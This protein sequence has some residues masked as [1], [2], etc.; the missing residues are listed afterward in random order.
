MLTVSPQ[1]RRR[2]IMGLQGLY[3]GRRWQ[4]K[5]GV[6]DAFAAMGELQIDPLNV[7]ARSHDI[8]LWGR[9]TGYKP[10]C[11]NDLLYEDRKF[12]DYG[13]TV[14]IRPMETLP[15]WRLI[16]ERRK[17]SPRY[18]Q[19]ITAY[20]TILDTVREHI[21][22]NGA[23]TSRM[24][25]KH[26]DKLTNSGYRT[27]NVTGQALYHLWLTGE[28]MTS[29]REGFERVYD[30]RESVAPSEYHHVAEV[31]EAED[32][33]ARRVLQV[34]GMTTTKKWRN[35]FSG[36]IERKVTPEE[37]TQR[38][39]R[40]EQH[41]DITAVAVEG[42]KEGYWVRTQDLPLLETL[43]A[44]RI[45]D[46]WRP[47]KLTTDH[48]VTFLAPLEIVSARG[49]AMTLFGF[50]YVW[51]VYKPV[52]KRKFGYYTLPI[53]YGDDLVG[54]FDPKLDRATQTLY[55]NGPWWDEEYSLDDAALA[56]AYEQGLARFAEFV[57]A[58]V[59][60]PME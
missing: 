27:H 15:Y 51:E 10:E 53:L 42:E 55:I 7:V 36:D 28:L 35:G 40:L 44:G 24:V 34:V 32:F 26:P 23:T 6:V 50:E 29:R 48:E 14:Y 5:Q 43:H 22:R 17:N 19:L 46:E 20:P 1:T 25:E 16:M 37:A 56:T 2:F 33:F 31:D 39:A 59:I 58:M 21:E 4:D 13:G 12:F 52:E 54:R 60:K 8:A 45:P 41:G 3:P 9:V 49:R 18:L 57:G 38:L 47:L 30:L 11:L